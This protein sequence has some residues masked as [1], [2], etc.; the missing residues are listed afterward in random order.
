MGHATMENR[1]GPACSLWLMR[2]SVDG[3]LK[4]N[5]GEDKAYDTADHVANLRALNVT[6][7]VRQNNSRRSADRTTRQQRY[8]MPQSRRAISNASS[9][10]QAAWHAQNKNIAHLSR[11]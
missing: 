9:V 2:P 1:H 6:Q 7:H 5:A 11:C 4:I 3:M 8:G 10:G